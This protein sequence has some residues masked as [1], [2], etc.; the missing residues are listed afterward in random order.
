MKRLRDVLIIVVLGGVV[1][2]FVAGFVH[3]THKAYLDMVVGPREADLACMEDHVI[4]H[5]GYDSFQSVEDAE[6][7]MKSPEHLAAVKAR[8]EQKQHDEAVNELKRQGIKKLKAICVEDGMYNCNLIDEN[9]AV[10]LYQVMIDNQAKKEA[11][12]AKQARQTATAQDQNS[13]S[14]VH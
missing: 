6:A 9:D 1:I 2:W 14:A 13:A 8:E 11:R 3:S 5:V 10:W 7:Y 4:C 12:K